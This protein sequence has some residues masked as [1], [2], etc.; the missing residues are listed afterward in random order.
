[1]AEGLVGEV[2]EVGGRWGLNGVFLAVVVLAMIDNAER[3][4]QPFGSRITTAW[5]WRSP[6]A[7]VQIALFVTP[8]LVLLSFPLGHPLDL[9]FSTFENLAVSLAVATVAYLFEGARLRRSTRGLPWLCISCPDGSS[10]RRR[11]ASA[12]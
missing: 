11:A 4:R 7:S 9:R 10:R 12:Q 1:V 3:T 6:Q 5:N 2:E 8:L